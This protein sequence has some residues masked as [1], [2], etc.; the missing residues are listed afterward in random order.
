M[1]EDTRYFIMNY[2]QGRDL[3]TTIAGVAYLCRML[4]LGRT[5]KLHGSYIKH[6][7]DLT[8]HM[9][10]NS[11]RFSDLPLLPEDESVYRKNHGKVCY[12]GCN[13]REMEIHVIRYTKEA[14]EPKKPEKTGL[15]GWIKSLFW[16]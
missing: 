3:D 8:N 2:A 14:M 9:I 1:K 6:L 12:Q 16:R 7:A 10:A 11:D 5:D 13:H 4:W 15:L